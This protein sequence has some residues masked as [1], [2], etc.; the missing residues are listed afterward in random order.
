MSGRDYY[1]YALLCEDGAPFYI[2]ASQDARRFDNHRYGKNPVVTEMRSR[3]VKPELKIIKKQ[4]SRI[5]ALDMERDIIAG[6]GR[7]HLTNENGG[8]GKVTVSTEEWL[9]VG[10]CRDARAMLNWSMMDLA[11]AAGTDLWTI[12]DFEVTGRKIQPDTS[13]SIRIALELAGI[14]F[15]G[16]GVSLRRSRK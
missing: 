3:G 14:M 9:R 13:Q 5:E 16:E 2:G 10:K 6:I 15:N 1:V 12:I 8:V 11:T 7:D 4:L